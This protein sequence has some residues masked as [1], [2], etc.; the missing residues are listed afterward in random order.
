MKRPRDRC[1]RFVARSFCYIDDKGYPRIG[2]GPLRGI[3]LHRIVAAAKLGRPLKADEDVHHVDGD[4]LNFAPDNL[5]VMG[6]Q[7]H[8][9][10][11]AKQH[12]YLKRR[13]MELKSEW[14]EFFE[15]ERADGGGA[16]VTFP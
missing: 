13:D 5:K 12:H 15:H 1:G 8:G 14:E 3:R 2:A 6:H 16:D 11:S 9:C 10:V 7:Q 4:K